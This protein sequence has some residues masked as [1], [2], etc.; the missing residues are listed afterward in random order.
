MKIA[1]IGSGTMGMGIA[2]A[3][4]ECEGYKV[5]LCVITGKKL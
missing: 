3:F 2:Q 5:A 1:V 4:A